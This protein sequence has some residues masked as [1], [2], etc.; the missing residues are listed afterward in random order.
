MLKRIDTVFLPVK[1]LDDAINWYTEKLG[2]TVRWRNEYGYAALNVGETALTL[3]ESNEEVDYKHMPF[4]FFVEDI[5]SMY[6]HFLNNDVKVG[7][8]NE[9]G[10][11]AHFDFEDL[12]GNPLGICW[13]E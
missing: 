2:L 12:Y 8:L 7:K 9:Y 4:N 1:N 10:N 3:V 13:F 6:D 11:F 5:G